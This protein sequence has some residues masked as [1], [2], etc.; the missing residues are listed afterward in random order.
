MNIF[1]FGKQYYYKSLDDEI[2]ALKNRFPDSPK[3]CAVRLIIKNLFYLFSK[4]KKNKKKGSE[5]EILVKFCGGY[6]DYIN[7]I[8]WLFAF[9]KE[10]NSENIK[11]TV[12]GNQKQ[13]LSLFDDSFNDVMV[14]DE[15]NNKIDFTDY[16]LVLSIVTIPAPLYQNLTRIGKLSVKLMEY[17]TALNTYQ[18]S[19]S[20]NF[21]NIPDYR[22]LTELFVRGKKFSST[23]DFD[24]RLGL[25]DKYSYRIP[26][27][28]DEEAVINKF[29]LHGKKFITVNRGWDQCHKGSH[30]KAMS[31]DSCGDLIV[32]LKESFPDFMIIAIGSSREQAMDTTGA[33][34]DLIEKTS[35]E[36]VK[37]ILH[38]ASVHIGCEGGLV[39]LRH[40]MGSGPCVVLFGPTNKYYYGY[41]ENENLSASCNCHLKT[42]CERI[43]KNYETLCLETGNSES[44]CMK[45]ITS[46][47]VVNKVKRILESQ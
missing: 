20:M 27:F 46:E 9:R 28:L 29:N 17:C 45:S 43:I 33:D 8:N 18:H 23:P 3:K 1:C 25:S 41:S 39:H 42:G 31:L 32:R 5:I 30:V 2:I 35:L 34:M 47:M 7:N 21:F 15:K 12:F 24:G 37:I 26:F 40:A 38:K 22:L 4:S 11:Y 44:L 19:N 10:F 16:D 36:E 13:L 6:G 14:I